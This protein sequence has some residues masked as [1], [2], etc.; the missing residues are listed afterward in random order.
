MIRH[1]YTGC[2]TCHVDPSGGYLLTPYGR[3]QTQALLSTFGHQRTEEGASQRGDFAWGVARLPAWLNVGASFRGAFMAAKEVSP[4]QPPPVSRWLLMQADV[5]AAITVDRFLVTGSMGYLIN[6]HNAAQISHGARDV[7]VS[8]EFWAGYYFGEDR[9]TLIRA[10]RLYLPFGLRVIEHPFYV[11]SITGTNIDSQQQYGAALFHEGEGY[12]AELMAIAGNF[13]IFPDSYRQRGYAGYAEFS[14]GPRL[15]F[16][17]SSLLTHAKLDLDYP[18]AIVRGAHGVMLRWSPDPALA[19]LA[20][21]DVVH[22]VIDASVNHAGFV[23]LAQLDY[24][25]IRGLHAIASTEFYLPAR[26]GALWNN[27]DWLSVAWFAYPHLDLRL[28]GYWASESFVPT[29]RVNSVAALG[30]LHVSL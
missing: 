13:Q 3:A 24:E 2:G 6:G 12:R 18:A 10:G 21:A 1:E 8:R 26:Q 25:F 17:A 27:R 11:R 9:E 19:I 7:L 14:I 4:A 29:S 20:E 16:G 28:D 5:R 22:S 30:Q 15:Q 23:S